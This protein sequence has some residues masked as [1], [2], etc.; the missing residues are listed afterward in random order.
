M[1][2]LSRHAEEKAVC[3]AVQPGRFIGGVS[4]G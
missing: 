3:E 2:Q 1:E 4:G